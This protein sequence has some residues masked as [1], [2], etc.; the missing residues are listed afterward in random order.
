VHSLN[1]Y[2]EECPLSG[3]KADI[4]WRT[5]PMC[6]AHLDPGCC[7]ARVR[8]LSRRQILPPDRRQLQTVTRCYEGS[9]HA[10]NEFKIKSLTSK[11]ECYRHETRCLSGYRACRSDEDHSASTV[12][13]LAVIAPS[14]PRRLSSSLGAANGGSLFH[15]QARRNYKS[16]LAPGFHR[17]ILAFTNSTNRTVINSTIASTSQL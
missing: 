7:A 17:S 3:G 8:C 10:L 15:R 13:L 9:R 14:S 1:L 16:K 5:A 12:Y 4:R 2:V 6:E 11:K